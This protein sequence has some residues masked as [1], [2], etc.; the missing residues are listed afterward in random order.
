MSPTRENLHKMIDIVDNSEIAF[1]FHMLRKLIPE[2]EPLPD[3]IECIRIASETPNEYILDSD[4]E[5]D[6]LEHYSD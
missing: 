1:V 3:E 2:N 5:W 6:N 4:I